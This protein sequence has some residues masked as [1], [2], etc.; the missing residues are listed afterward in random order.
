MTGPE[1]LALANGF[2]CLGAERCVYCGAAASVLYALP[3]SFTTRDTLRCPGS[4][5]IC[6]GCRL[7]TEEVGI[8]VYP[9]NERYHFTK[10]FRR[11]CSWVVTE[12]SAY[13]ATKGHIEY[14]RSACLHPPAPPYMISLAVSGQKH[15]LYRSV[16]NHDNINIVVTLEGEPIQYRPHELKDRLA[17]CGRLVSATGKPALA[18]TPKPSFWIR[19]CERFALGESWCSEWEQVRNEPLTRLAAF[20]CPAK[21]ASEREYPSDRHDGVPSASG[22]PDRPAP[23][24]G[25]GRIAQR[26]GRSNPTLFGNV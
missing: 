6:R 11:M 21:E 24:D 5:F 18:E 7:A 25:G 16:V 26:Q 9:T 23:K 3:D 15:V 17:L 19:V 14:L 8:A 20:L 10:A 22:G 2:H 4:K 1:L 13:A 12:N